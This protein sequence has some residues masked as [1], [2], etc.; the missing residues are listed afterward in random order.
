MIP[1][2]FWFS[3]RFNKAESIVTVQEGHRLSGYGFI[4]IKD[5]ITS[6]IKES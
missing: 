6:I 3:K 5:S 4:E 1:K 2:R